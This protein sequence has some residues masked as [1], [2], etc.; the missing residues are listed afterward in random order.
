MGY[1]GY[2]I[3]RSGLWADIAVSV[4]DV[5]CNN[6]TNHTH[7]ERETSASLASGIAHGSSERPTHYMIR[8][9]PTANAD[10]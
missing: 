10:S 6:N 3:V 2:V 4:M 7:L 9:G 1:R 5:V 8:L